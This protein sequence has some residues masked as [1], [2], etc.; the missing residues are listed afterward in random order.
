V[1]ARAEGKDVAAS[2]LQQ[3]VQG[4]QGMKSFMAS[5]KLMES[6]S[7]DPILFDILLMVFCQ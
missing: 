1:D 5:R 2:W 4:V 6:A 3:V 7:T